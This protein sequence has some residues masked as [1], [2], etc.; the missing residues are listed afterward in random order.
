MSITT[1]TGDAG[2]TSLYSGE[3]IWK[4]ELRV[5]AY[6][7]LD[8]LG[9][10]LGDA[11]HLVND[12]AL[13]DILREVQETLYRV[14]GQLAARDAP[15]PYPLSGKEVA[16]LT[17]RIRTLEEQTPLEGFVIPGSLP[18]SAR[19]DI[20]RAVA[21]RAER[22]LVR[23]ARA[24]TVAPELLQYVNRLSD[25]LFIVARTLEATAGA[26]RYAPRPETEP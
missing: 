3:R 14:M 7:S 5:E 24:E 26:I 25:L 20:C 6:G 13:Q 18:A 2:Q 11:R 12:S 23:L 15:F 21:R 19:L 22:R 16:A 4:D 9:S 17:G 1:K 8:G 10:F